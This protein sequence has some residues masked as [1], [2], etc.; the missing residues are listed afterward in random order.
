MEIGTLISGIVEV[1]LAPVL[2]ILLLWKGFGL[3]KEWIQQMYELRIGQRIILSKLNA[4][5]EYDKAI[6]EL[7]ERETK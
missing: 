7:K 5:E 4:L 6:Q 3:L 2:V 1:G